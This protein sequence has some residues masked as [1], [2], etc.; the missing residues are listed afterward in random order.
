M[1]IKL[2]LILNQTNSTPNLG[3][4]FTTSGGATISSTLK[5][6]IN[7]DDIQFIELKCAN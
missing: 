5:N 2:D 1:Q 3:T 6:V 4:T 7:L